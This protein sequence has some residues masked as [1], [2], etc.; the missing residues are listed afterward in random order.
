MLPA[1]VRLSGRQVVQIALAWIVLLYRGF[2]VMP[3]GL[4]F[5]W[6]AVGAAYWIY[7]VFGQGSRSWPP[8]TAAVMA[9]LAALQF[10]AAGRAP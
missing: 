10:L 2:C 3:A 4:P 8:A 5:D 6:M 9:W 1:P 7:A